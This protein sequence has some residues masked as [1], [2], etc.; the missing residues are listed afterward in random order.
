MSQKKDSLKGDAL[1]NRV[2]LLVMEVITFTMM[3]GYVSDFSAGITSL[4][5]FLIFQLAAM[6]TFVLLPIVYKKSPDKMKHVASVCFTV[7]YTLACFGAHIDVGF[8]M[9]FPIVVI[10]ILYYDFNLIRRVTVTFNI[11]VLLDVIY[12]TFG[13]KRLHSGA[14]LNTSVVIMEFLSTTIF[15][16]TVR[17][18]TKISNR[19][20]EEKLNK[21]Q[22]DAEKVNMSVQNINGDII[23]L[24]QASRAV[25]GAMEEINL[26]VGN[27]VDAVQNQMLQTEAIQNQIEQV[28]QAADQV[29]DNLSQTL[30]S[31]T[32]GNGEVAV[33]AAKADDCGAISEKVTQDLLDLRS[34]IENMG[35]ITKIIENIAFHTNIMALNANVEAARAGE[36]GLGFAVVAS[37]ISNM[38][39]KTKE[40]TE[41]IE[42][43]I[44]NANASL[45]ALVAS[46]GDLDDIVQAQKNQSAQTSAMFDSIQ[47]STEEVKEHMNR[48]M[49]YLEG[50][51]SANKEI[52]MSVQTISATTQE[53][54]ALTHE[55]TSMETNNAV[56]VQSI[57]DKLAELCE[58]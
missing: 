35:A 46:V 58:A 12:Q 49:D 57:V 40:A 47:G 19:N 42:E 41:N 43:L 16:F 7:V 24:N 17:A 20:N 1:V 48:F 37:E 18:I 14:E 3:L 33:L 51:T 36:A 34:K 28:S 52:V 15:C 53:L 6:V 38:S 5:Y 21:I 54:G 29:A 4:R 11:V 10:F 26:G 9:A 8:V 32:Q 39:A 30:A 22:A 25:K 2:V 45:Q 13:V 50:L 31:V 27:V 44:K 23:S 55:A 56:A